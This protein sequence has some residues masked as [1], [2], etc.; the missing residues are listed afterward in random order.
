MAR[1]HSRGGGTS[2]ASTFASKRSIDERGFSLCPSAKPVPNYAHVGDSVRLERSASLDAAKRSAISLRQSLGV[3]ENALGGSDI[4][5][6][7]FLAIAAIVTASIRRFEGAC[8][9]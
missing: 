7:V 8:L 1:R 5:R 6:G 2:V 4:R 3:R 9:Y